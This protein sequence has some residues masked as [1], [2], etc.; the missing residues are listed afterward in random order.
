MID[1]DEIRQKVAIKHNV[2]LGKDDPILV[3]VTINELVLGRYLDLAS[4]RYADASRELTVS[5]EQQ[6]EQAKQTAGRVITD[7]SDYVAKE[8]RQ[9]VMSA[10]S[11]AG[12]QLRQQIA[13]A[14]GVAREA[15]ASG[16]A[17]QSA[18]TSAVIAAVIASA[19]AVI[20]IAAVVVVLVK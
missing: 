2:L 16:N 18:K 8:V 13:D 11:D 1:F 15:V 10:V 5:I 7:A 20:A 4:E 14:Q 9:A 19:T 6:V 12:A 17:A 3:T